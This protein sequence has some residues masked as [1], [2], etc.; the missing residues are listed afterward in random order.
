MIFKT[1]RIARMI[2]LAT[3]AL[4]SA[5]AARANAVL[6]WNAIAVSTAVAN[7]QNFFVLREKKHRFFLW[8]VLSFRG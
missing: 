6:D 7:K 8:Y 4:S 1:V 5:E 3:F 2:V